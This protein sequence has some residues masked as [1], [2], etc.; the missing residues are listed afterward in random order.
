MRNPHDVI[1]GMVRTE[2]GAMLLPLNQYLFWVD[3]NAN[4]IEIKKAI[5]DIYKVKVC[6]VNTSIVRGK[7]KR[8]R[9]ATGYTSEW[10]KAIATLKEGSKIEVA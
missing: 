8:V 4:K 10:K 7:A 1:K 9:Y 3:R 6:G 5:E 2:K